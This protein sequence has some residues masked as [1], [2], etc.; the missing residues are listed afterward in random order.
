MPQTSEL[1]HINFR[2]V[3]NYCWD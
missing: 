1:N 2:K 3:R